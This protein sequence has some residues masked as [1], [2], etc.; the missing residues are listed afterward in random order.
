[1]GLW[2]RQKCAEQG[3]I[4]AEIRSAEENREMKSALNGLPIKPCQRIYRIALRHR[5]GN[6]GANFFSGK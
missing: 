6:P 1:M 4:L 3:G 2:R 5:N